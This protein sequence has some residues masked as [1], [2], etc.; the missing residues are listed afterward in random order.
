VGGGDRIEPV[1]IIVARAWASYTSGRQ[2]HC[3]ARHIAEMLAPDPMIHEIASPTKNFR[4]GGIGGV[5]P[6]ASISVPTQLA[7]AAYVVSPLPVTTILV[8]T[9]P[10]GN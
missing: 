2:E 10:A 7:S 4:G 9:A 3:D 1:A 6:V 8:P 5:P